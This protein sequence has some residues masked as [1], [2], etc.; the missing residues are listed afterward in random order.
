MGTPTRRTRLPKHVSDS[1]TQV[2]QDHIAT[3]VLLVLG[4]NNH[5]H[6]L[7]NTMEQATRAP[8]DY[9]GQ[10]GEQHQWNRSLL[11]KYENLHRRPLHRL[12]W[13]SSPV[14]RSKPGNPKS[15]KQTY[16]APNWTKL[17]TIATRDNRE[18]TKMFTRAKHNKESTP[19]R[20]VWGTSQAGVT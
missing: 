15:T 8:L 1:T 7:E 3:K 4:T 6:L 20:P 17:E 9:T 11:T 14:D 2:G 19:F 18:H 10:A 5:L 13:C 16:R 12:G